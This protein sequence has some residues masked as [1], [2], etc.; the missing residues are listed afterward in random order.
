MAFWTTYHAPGEAGPRVDLLAS[1][2]TTVIVS[3]TWTDIAAAA[4]TSSDNVA[5]VMRAGFELDEV[6][7]VGLDGEKIVQVGGYYYR[8]ALEARVVDKAT[9][10]E[11][12]AVLNHCAKGG[13]FKV[14]FYPH[15]DNTNIY[16]KAR[17]GGSIGDMNVKDNPFAGGHS[18]NLMVKGLEPFAQIPWPIS[19]GF[20]VAKRGEWGNYTAGEKEHMMVAKAGEWSSYDTTEKNTNL[21][22]NVAENEIYTFD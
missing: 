18:A 10:G 8:A 11:M 20:I 7:R 14:N 6:T 15:S 17:I 4:L 22:Y 9:A 16:F 3:Y 19:V 1:D 5:P 12:T 21:G 2:G 13:H